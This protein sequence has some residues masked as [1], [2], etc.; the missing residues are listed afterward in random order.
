MS[1]VTDL[2][3]RL[4]SPIV[5]EMGIELWDVEFVR[6]GGEQYLRILIDSKDGIYIDQC[7]DVSKAID[8]LLDELDIIKGPYILE[9]SSAG[10]ERGLKKPEH[11]ERYLGSLIE[12]RLYK[13]IEGSKRYVGILRSFE[14]DHI[15]LDANDRSLVIPLESVSKAS[16]KYNWQ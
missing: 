3:T 2:V 6:I 7:E 15:V 10:I 1:K 8:P 16:L 9:V 5:K 11:F 13:A 4:V 12:V 14:G